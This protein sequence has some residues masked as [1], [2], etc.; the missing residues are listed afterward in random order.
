M[1]ISPVLPKIQFVSNIQIH[2][3]LI[4]NRSVVRHV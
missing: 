2:E 1:P 4:S 3:K